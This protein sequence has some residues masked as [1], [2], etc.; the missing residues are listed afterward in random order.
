MLA[1]VDN[2]VISFEVDDGG[3]SFREE[4]RWAWMPFSLVQQIL[5]AKGEI[6]LPTLFGIPIVK[7]PKKPKEPKKTRS[8]WAK[9]VLG[10][11]R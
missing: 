1:V 9:A 11:Q 8:M 6:P 7:I 2:R 5:E 10:N 4:H 3:I